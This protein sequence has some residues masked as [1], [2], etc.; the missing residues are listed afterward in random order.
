M[1]CDISNLVDERAH[2]N[3][4]PAVQQYRRQSYNNQQNGQNAY[5]QQGHQYP[6]QEG[7]PYQQ[8]MRGAPLYQAGYNQQIVQQPGQG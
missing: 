4:R 8:P 6:I 2:N 3:T 7:Y 1:G 5:Q